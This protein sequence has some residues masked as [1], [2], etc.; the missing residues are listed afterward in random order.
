MR[1]RILIDGTK[2]LDPRTDGIKRY[3]IELLRA[4]HRYAPRDWTIDVSLDPGFTL[5]LAQ[6]AGHLASPN[7]SFAGVVPR[8][9]SPGPENPLHQIRDRV[10]QRAP[11]SVW[12]IIR[13]HMA[14][15]TFRT[16]RSGIRRWQ[17]FRRRGGHYDLVHLTLP[18]TWHHVAGLQTRLLATV[19][20]L[21]HLVCPQFQAPANVHSLAAGLAFCEH[22]RANY[23]AV[24][25]A[26]RHQLMQKLHVNAERVRTVHEGVDHTRFTP[27]VSAAEQRRVRNRYHLGGAPFVLCVGTVEPRKNLTTAVRAFRRLPTD[28]RSADTR[29]G[30]ATTANCNTT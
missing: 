21:C 22:R 11:R 25:N 14:L 23:I 15:Q 24:S 29:V 4:M 26:T 27:H 19:H 17:E 6:I 9:L 7:P 12:S 5:P 3:V 16:A 18:N 10:K 20:D 8:L 1:Q 28:R 30:V 2:L 13:D